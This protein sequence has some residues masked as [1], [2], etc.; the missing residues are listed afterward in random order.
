MAVPQT[1]VNMASAPRATDG[2]SVAFDTSGLTQV[3]VDV[4][5]TALNGVGVELRV[6]LERRGSD[7]VW[8]PIWTSPAITANGSTSISVGP[9]MEVARALG[10]LCRLR[11]TIAGTSASV[12]FSASGVGK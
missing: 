12:T 2:V 9:G 7:G 3:A 4:N 11:W 10:A 5:V 1:L 6:I 8:Y